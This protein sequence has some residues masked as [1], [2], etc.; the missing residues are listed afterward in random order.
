MQI[1]DIKLTLWEDRAGAAPTKVRAFVSVVF[2]GRFV[3]HDIKIIEGLKGL[4][5]VM[6]SRRL[7]D[8]CPSCKAKTAFLDHFC[9][10]CGCQLAALEVRQPELDDRGRRK[11]FVDT[12]HPVNQSMRSELETAILARYHQE[13]GKRVAAHGAIVCSG[14]VTPLAS[15][16]W[17]PVP[18]GLQRMVSGTINFG[19]GLL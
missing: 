17:L 2:D 1:T 15:G 11:V 12:C 14:M 18:G 19:S 10:A 16:S 8:A 6:P 7:Q 3:V 5:V 9:P 13:S 4:Y